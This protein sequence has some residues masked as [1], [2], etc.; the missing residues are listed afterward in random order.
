M[1]AKD[2]L[3]VAVISLGLP[4]LSGCLVPQSQLTAVETQNRVL[5]EQNRATGRNREPQG[6]IRTTPRTS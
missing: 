5:T 2:W 3:A 6:G 1:K 4:A